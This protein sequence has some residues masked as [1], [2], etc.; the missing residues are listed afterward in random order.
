MGKK[1]FGYYTLFLGTLLIVTCGCK[2]DA[3]PLDPVTDTEGNT[4]KTVKI[5]TQIWM[6]ENLKT[7]RYNDGADISLVTDAIKWGNLTT[8]GY[9]WY[10]ND[11]ASFKDTYGALYNGYTIETGKLCPAGWHIPDKQEWQVLREFLGDSLK[12]G[13]KLKEAGTAHWLAPNKGADNSS[14]FTALPAG[15]RYFEGTFSS[16]LS[17]TSIWS[18]TEVAK[19]EVWYTGLYFAEAAFIMDHRNKNHGFSVR[20]IKD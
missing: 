1:V 8:A 11:V 13:G 10:T 16:V 6:A 2:K 9:C 19:D 7:T 15:L 17:Y 3:P 4:Y 12:G 5:G 18:T 14:G 20:C